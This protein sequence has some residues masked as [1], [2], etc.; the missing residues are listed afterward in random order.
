MMENLETEQKIVLNVS[1]GTQ[2]LVI[3]NG[4]APELMRA[5]P[6]LK[7]T[8]RGT[9]DAPF[10]FLHKRLKA[11]QFTQSDSHILVDREKIT[12][13]LI[14][15][16]SDP[17]KE[18][19]VVGK[20]E[21]HPAFVKFGINTDKLWTPEELALFIKM[22]R[23]FFNDLKANMDL[24]TT[25][26]NY[27]GTINA[28]VERNRKENGSQTDNYAQVVNSNLPE[29]FMV[30]IPILKG[31]PAETLEIE[32]FAKVDGRDIQFALLS[33]SAA[34]TLEELRDKAIDEQLDKIKEF[35]P[36]LVIIEV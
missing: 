9:L 26:F 32:T 15:R 27:K 36:E 20:L 24:V 28:Q 19:V 12:I 10:E 8:I 7:T 25:L 30:N 13:T 1:E 4:E 31:K 14:I 6:P 23:A 2:E 35:A 22:N 3:R 33:P 16:E 29:K 34:Q 21:M 11:E 17:Y 5:L 18:G